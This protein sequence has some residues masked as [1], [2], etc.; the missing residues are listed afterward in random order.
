MGEG[1]TGAD[2]TDTDSAAK[3]GDSDDETACEHAVASELS[4]VVGI[5]V[6]ESVDFAL[7]LSLQDDGDDD[8]VDGNSLAENDRDQVLAHN[9]GHLDSRSDDG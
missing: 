1:G 2:N 6:F 5:E 9:T 8:T 4:L 7:K 3:V